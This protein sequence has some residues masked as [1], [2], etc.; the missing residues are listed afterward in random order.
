[1]VL[2]LSLVLTGLCL[3]AVVWSVVK[4]LRRSP[5]VWGRKADRGL[6]GLLMAIELGLLVQAV[7]GFVLVA[8]SA[9]GPGLTFGAY[10]V[11]VLFILPV[12]TLWA[13]GDTSRAG[14]GVLIVAG[15]TVPAMI[16]RMHQVWS[17]G[18]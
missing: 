18:A 17:G 3:V 16:L 2:G 14:S 10:L 12:G 11:G 6:I 4:I 13:L 7:L 8:S 5:L 9:D 15:L 1:M